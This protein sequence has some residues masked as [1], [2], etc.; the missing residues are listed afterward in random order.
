MAACS[1]RTKEWGREEADRL[2]LHRLASVQRKERKEAFEGEPWAG[3]TATIF[4]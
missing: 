1:D 4:L 3:L 2:R